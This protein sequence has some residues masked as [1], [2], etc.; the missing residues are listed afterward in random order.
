ML[1]HDG[2]GISE[3]QTWDEKEGPWCRHD[4]HGS[5]LHAFDV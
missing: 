2:M 4:I 5:Q 1:V 3:H